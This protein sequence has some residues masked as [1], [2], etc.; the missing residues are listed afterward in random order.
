MNGRVAVVTGGGRGIGRAIGMRLARDGYSVILAARTKDQ[1]DEAAA[2]I[3]TS[4]GLAEGY[5]LDI[6]DEVAVK[7]A[8][9]SIVQTHGRIDVLVNSAGISYVAP[10]VMGKLAEWENVLRV[11]VLGA[12]IVSRAVLRPML[13]A[14]WG[15]IIHIGSIS[16]QIGA[17]HNAIY[18]ASKA[19]I[20]GLVRSLALEVAPTGITVNGIQPGTVRTE[21]YRK[22][23]SVRAKIKG[24]SLDQQ[25]AQL[26]SEV[27]I[28]R[29]V[30]PSEVAGA[31]AF[32]AS[33]DA[34]SI[35]GQLLTLDGGRTIR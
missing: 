26:I 25:D 10:V 34:A 15:R 31:V 24:I 7:A 28:G 4:G 23:H 18:A 22:M 27:P 30:E 33:D 13:K 9:S 11:N 20:A 29:L 17:S 32:L 8:V 35:V 21:L 16:G 2:D 5:E 12:F 6:T 14:R 1:V 19:G 3:S